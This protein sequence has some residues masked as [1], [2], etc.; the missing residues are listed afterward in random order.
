MAASEDFQQRQER[1]QSHALVN[2]RRYKYIP[3]FTQ[4]AV[5]LDISLGGFKVEFTGDTDARAGDQYWLEI[6]LSPLGIYQPKFLQ[7]RVEVR[8]FDE[9]RQR[10]GGVFVNL[11]KN[12]QMILD[13]IIKTLKERG[14][15]G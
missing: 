4:S 10:V 2:M 11:E 6:P 7:I 5:L 8:W 1:Y 15:L 14:G 13:L 12:E 3:F 9:R